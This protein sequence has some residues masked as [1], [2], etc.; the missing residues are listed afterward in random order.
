M[1]FLRRVHAQSA[2]DVKDLVDIQ[3]EGVDAKDYP[4]FTDAYITH[5]FNKKTN[6]ELTEKELDYLNDNYSDFIH[7]QAHESVF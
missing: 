1:S 4:K 7:E 5:A 6:K 2:F 3:V